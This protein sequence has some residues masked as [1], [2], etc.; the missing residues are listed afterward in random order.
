MNEFINRS[1]FL[2]FAFIAYF[3]FV[4]QVSYSQITA[5]QV[6]MY[7][8]K[9][10]QNLTSAEMDGTTD[11]TTKLQNAVNASRDAKQTLFIPS[12]TYKISSQI[13]CV[14]THEEGSNANYPNMAVNIVGSAIDHPTIILADNTA[15]FN[16]A[17][18]KA[19]FHYMTDQTL[20]NPFNDNK[21][22][23]SSWIMEGGIRGIDIDLG[24]GN[25]N[26]VGIFWASAQ[27]CYLEDIH[28]N[29]RDGFAGFTGIGGA[30]SLLANTKVTG[31]KYGL[32]LPEYNEG[33][34]IGMENA[35]QNTIV[36]C[37]FIDQTEVPVSL[38]SWGGI[39]MVGIN[40]ITNSNTAINLRCD[41]T[42]YVFPFSLIDS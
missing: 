33:I 42:V 4:T 30:N 18:P 34:S 13:L 32:Y 17:N 40:I 1:Q 16:G 8:F 2:K 29:A 10:M 41:N 23:D 9:V 28:I 26:A 14:M 35:P 25:S 21:P 7:D 19:L 37:T 24:S 31:G 5:T 11:V 39:T 20:E 3:F 6:G 27:H 38:W 15:A 12:G 36:A 22:F